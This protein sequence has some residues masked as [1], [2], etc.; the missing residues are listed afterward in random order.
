MTLVCSRQLKRVQLQLV[1]RGP[2][3]IVHILFKQWRVA[4]LQTIAQACEALEGW[5]HGWCE[6]GPGVRGRVEPR[7]QA[8]QGRDGLLWLLL[9]VLW[10]E[11]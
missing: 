3:H 4:H 7:Q 10:L 5:R 9:L 2:Q 1:V 11:W 8:R 6:C